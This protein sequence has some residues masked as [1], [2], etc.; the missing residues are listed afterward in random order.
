MAERQAD[1]LTAASEAAESW[2]E[3]LRAQTS[4]RMVWWEEHGVVQGVLQKPWKLVRRLLPNDIRPC[5]LACIEPALY[6]A[7]ERMEQCRSCPTTGG[8]CDTSYDMRAPKGQFPIWDEEARDIQFVWCARHREHLLRE[9]LKVFGVPEVMLGATFE[10]FTADD[11]LRD[12]VRSYA[13]HFDTA[14]A[15][16][17]HFVGATGTGKSHLAA[18]LVRD[19]TAR[20]L[21]SSACFAF[22]PKLFDDMRANF[23]RS[24]EHRDELLERVLRSDVLILD[25]LG[26]ERT[27]D[28]VRDQLGIVMHE[29][30]AN[31]KPVLVTSNLPL[32]SYRATLGER[33]HSRLKALTPYVRTIHGKDRRSP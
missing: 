31:N 32:D 7:Q 28:W 12:E 4:Q 6:W 11:A 18:A 30:W 9:R 17:F 10:N 22:V 33:A 13:E 29:R 1:Q 23:D 3:E 27:T 25:D 21:I 14:G 8:A 24:V 5:E 26:A 16:S 20:R 15:S 19:I 2:L